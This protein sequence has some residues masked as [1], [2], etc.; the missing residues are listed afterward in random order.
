[1][2]RAKEI[3]EGV[4]R[5]DELYTIERAKRLLGL[6]DSAMRAL[7]M[8]GLPVI[9]FGKRAFVSGRQ[10]ILFF[11]TMSDGTGESESGLPESEGPTCLAMERPR[12]GSVDGAGSG[13]PS[14]EG[15]GQARRAA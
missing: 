12:D 15:G 2:V 11:E 14:A 3:A 6:T 5:V 10:L 13:E 4:V 7:R 9:R 8:A 1:M